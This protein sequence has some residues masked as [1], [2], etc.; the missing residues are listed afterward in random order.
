MGLNE[1]IGDA[2]LE[3]IPGTDLPMPAQG[4]HAYELYTR[5]KPDQYELAAQRDK[6]TW[7][8]RTNEVAIEARKD[9]RDL[10]LAT[11]EVVIK[12]MEEF[13]DNETSASTAM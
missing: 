1:T 9:G 5:Y 8:E 12:L 7:Y 4:T 6:S 13:W 2:P 10:D 11:M 3:T